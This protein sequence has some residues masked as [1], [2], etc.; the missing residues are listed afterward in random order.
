MKL[1][2]NTVLF[3]QLDLH[4]ALQHI[5]WAGYEGAELAYLGNMAQHIEPNTDQPYL[6]YV[7]STARRHRLELFAVEA[8]VGGE[9]EEERIKALVRIFEVANK[10]GIPIVAVGSGGKA[11]DPG[12]TKETFRYIGK[13]AEQAE[14]WQITLAVKP[15][16]GASVYNTETALGMLAEV[17]SP[18]LGI[19]FDPSHIYRAGENPEES[20]LR[21]GNGIVH[22]HFRDCPH[23]EHSPGLPEQQIPGRGRIDIPGTLRS[24]KDV[25]Y[26]GALDLEVIG[27][28]TYPLSRQMGIAAEARGYLNRCLQELR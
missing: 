11:G 28:F 8:T 19:N 14:S 18:A 16:V 23:Q 21:I 3:N 25:G 15:H 5:S 22:S 7:K 17:E 2:C 10:M 12:I 24:L 6:D 26:D 20:A 13:L 4:G 1:G 27:A 9:R